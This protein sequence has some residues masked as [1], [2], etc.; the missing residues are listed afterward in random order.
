MSCELNSCDALSFQEESTFH[1]ALPYGAGTLAVAV[2]GT[3]LAAT[4][5]VTALK[6]VGITAAFFGAFAFMGTV[7]CGISNS[8]NA[9]KFR[10]EI[11]KYMTVA[12]GQAVVE[13]TIQVASMVL[14]QMIYNCLNDRN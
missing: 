13:I 5:T 14:Q 11:F 3:V 6:I 2:G 4:A 1:A 8:G 9:Q 10:E 7:L 12:V